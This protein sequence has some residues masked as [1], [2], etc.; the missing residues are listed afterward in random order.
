MTNE[1]TITVR[2]LC[3]TRASIH[4]IELKVGVTVTADGLLDAC[5]EKNG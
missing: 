5:R 3:F 2:S 4:Y 1:L